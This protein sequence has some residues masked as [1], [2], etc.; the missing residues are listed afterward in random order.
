MTKALDYCAREGRRCWL[1]AADDRVVWSGDV[2]RR[3]GA[4]AQLDGGPRPAL[5]SGDEHQ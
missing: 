2:V 3:I 5:P 1:Y 4:S